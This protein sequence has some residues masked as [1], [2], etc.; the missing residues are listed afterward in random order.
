[1]TERDYNAEFRKTILDY[2]KR[3]PE[4]MADMYVSLREELTKPPEGWFN[5]GHHSSPEM[6]GAPL[7]WWGTGDDGMPM[8]ERPVEEHAPWCMSK[9]TCNCK[10]LGPRT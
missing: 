2:A 10:P 8:W 4:G 5:F 1:M 6:A 3:D 7:E 9:R